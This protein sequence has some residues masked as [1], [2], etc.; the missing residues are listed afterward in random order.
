MERKMATILY[1]ILLLVGL[2]NS[3]PAQ[4]CPF[5][6]TWKLD[7][8]SVAKQIPA[9]PD[10]NAAELEMI[11]MKTDRLRS[12]RYILNNTSGVIVNE[13]IPNVITWKSSRIDNEKFELTNPDGIEKFTVEMKGPDRLVL[14]AIVERQGSEQKSTFDLVRVSNADQWEP[15]RPMQ[16]GMNAPPITTQFWLKEPD[17]KIE[18]GDGRTYL[19]EFWATWCAP[20]IQKMPKLVELQR[21]FGLDQM[22]V[23]AVTT[24]SKEAVITFV[25]R[26]KVAR[27]SSTGIDISQIAN[28]ISIGV[29]NESSSFNA[30]MVASGFRAIPTRFIVGKTGQIEWAG[31][32]D[33]YEDVLRK[34]LDGSWDRKS[35]AEKFSGVQRAYLE[36]PLVQKLLASGKPDD[37]LAL[38]TELELHADA[39]MKATLQMA[40]SRLKS[41]P[42]ANGQS[43]QAVNP[44][45]R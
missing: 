19:V 4:E 31:V 33:E 22:A 42:N 17:K 5:G 36:Y 12:V 44:S 3:L 40:R 15:P 45:R 43:N 38:I 6:G 27:Q 34:V 28:A 37:A 24:E 11:A 20:C 1:A 32:G 10:K 39:Q 16:I 2:G 8:E 25:D 13:G 23:V 29:D 26:R 9:T 7:M 30:Y 35:F 41:P 21:E 14:T 18:F